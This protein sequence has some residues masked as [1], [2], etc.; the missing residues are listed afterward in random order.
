M[1]RRTI[2]GTPRGPLAPSFTPQTR[3]ILLCLLAVFT[4]TVMDALAKYLSRDYPPLQV[5]WARYAG[6]AVLVFMILLPMGRRVMVTRFPLM[7]AARSVLQFGATACFFLSLPYIGLAEATALTDLN[8]V[9]ITLGAAFF[10]GETIGLRRVLGVVA[11]LVGALIVIRPGM[12]VFQPA[13]LLPLATAFCYAGFALLTRV[14]GDRESIWTSLFYTALFGTVI[15]TLLMPLVWTPIAARDLWGFVGVGLLGT[16]AQLCLIRAFTLAPASVIAPF[17]YVGLV[18]AS[19]WGWVF[20]GQVPDRWTV[21][22]A[23]VI[24]GAGLYVWARES[25]A[26]RSL[27]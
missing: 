8:P 27:R 7:Q 18:F 12:G 5:V 6:Q 2:D 19:F 17:G 14:V 20:F 11:A 3:G 24:V 25:A 4:F 15:G 26:A 13:A 21:L 23:L 9:L 16:T 1:S 22:G 10:L